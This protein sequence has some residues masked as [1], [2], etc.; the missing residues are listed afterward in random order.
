MTL[1]PRSRASGGV[2]SD[3]P[4]PPRPRR[5]RTAARELLD[6][7][8]PRVAVLHEALQPR[9]LVP[10]VLDL[11]VQALREAARD[12]QVRPHLVAQR[13]HVAQ[14]V[15]DDGGPDLLHRLRRVP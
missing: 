2:A 13:E 6:P 9:L 7:P 10:L 1:L 14:V 3:P 5:A 8:P 15:V 11:H 12:V 4:K